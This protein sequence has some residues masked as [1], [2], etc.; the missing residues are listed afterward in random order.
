MRLSFIREAELHELSE[1]FHNFNLEMNSQS[2][3]VT[4][5]AEFSEYSPIDW[6]IW[7]ACVHSRG[8]D[9]NLCSPQ[10]RRLLRFLQSLD[11]APH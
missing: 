8:V 11:I 3:I 5:E 4:A 7:W 9:S 10:V 1:Y 6:F 2:Q